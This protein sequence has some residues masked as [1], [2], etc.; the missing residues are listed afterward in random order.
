MSHIR[1]VKK[2][3]SYVAERLSCFHLSERGE[4]EWEDVLKREVEDLMHTCLTPSIRILS[5]DWDI[6]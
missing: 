6:Y 3:F 4:K 2:N 5:A 1:E